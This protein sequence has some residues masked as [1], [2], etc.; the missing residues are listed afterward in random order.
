MPYAAPLNA[1]VRRSHSIAADAWPP[2]A[3]TMELKQQIEKRLNEFISSTGPDKLGLRAV[4]AELNALPLLLDMG[5]CYA[6]R[7][8]GEI[9]SFA[10]DDEKNFQ[11]EQDRRTKNIALYEGSQKYPELSELLSARRS[12]DQDCPH[13]NGTGSLPIN[14]KLGV[15]NI[16]CYCGGLGWIPKE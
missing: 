14:A 3:I 16:L 15:K 12:E 10:W 5:G 13:C 6:I 8:D 9:I 11:V 7:P 4:A 1:G 2:I